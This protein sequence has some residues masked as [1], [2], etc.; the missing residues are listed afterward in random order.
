M[1]PLLLFTMLASYGVPALA[2]VSAGGAPAELEF[3]PPAAPPS[4]SVEPVAENDAGSTDTTPTSE[5]PAEPVASSALPP[6][7][8]SPGAVTSSDHPVQPPVPLP[9]TPEAASSP[10]P[11]A[12]AEAEKAP[13]KG[14]A[15][16]ASKPSKVMLA[17]HA[18][19]TL[20]APRGNKSSEDRARAASRVLQQALDKHVDADVHTL[21]QGNNIAIAIGDTTVVVLTAED[22]RLAQA[23]SLEAYADGIADSVEEALES[24]QQRGKIA[25]RVFSASLVVFF[26]LIAF[27]L[28]RKTSEW[29]ESAR[30]WLETRGDRLAVRVRQLEI[31][32]PEVAETAALFALGALKWLGRVGI[33][34]AWLVLALSMFESTSGYTARLT[35]WVIGPLSDLTARIASALPVLVV[36][37]LALVAIWVLLR[38]VQLL[39]E[40]VARRETTLAWVP[41]DLAR[42]TSVL[43]RL[44]IVLSALVFA[45]PIVTGSADGALARSGLIALLSLGLAATPLLASALVGG[46]NVFG[47]SLRAG[48]HV[49][50]TTHSGRIIKLGLFELGL[51]LA[52]GSEM[53]VPYLSFVWSRVRVLGAHPLL[54][55]ELS[56][57]AKTPIASCEQALRTAA[58]RVGAGVSVELL[59]ADAAGLRF[60]VAVRGQRL[61]QRSELLKNC[62]EAIGAA[63]IELGPVGSPSTRGQ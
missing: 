26:G 58:G 20:S 9:S 18:V 1:R 13:A 27:Y 59:S 41:P 6:A 42:P 36:A 3:G 49:E 4:A 17:E 52:D 28:L 24:E 32:A 2:D 39:F 63:G 29:A 25:K 43:L 55:V 47:R 51:E 50:F 12:S 10:S 48:D 46:V 38:F 45:A 22:A 40:G 37:G 7:T 56:V 30:E 8:A 11:S 19:F 34:Y 57:V 60:R 5:P 61:G 35:G 15:A 21:P 33:V 31:V 16:K 14:D 54:S 53:R 62:L 23:E 44:G